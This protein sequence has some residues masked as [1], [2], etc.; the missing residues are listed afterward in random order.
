MP[1]CSANASA[2]PSSASAPMISQADIE[3][4]G[5]EVEGTRRIPVRLFVPG[6]RKIRLSCRCRRFI[7]A[8]L[9]VHYSATGSSATKLTRHEKHLAQSLLLFERAAGTERDAG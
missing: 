7:T 5:F 9:P 6:L 3:R 8:V 4:R 2:P 1:R